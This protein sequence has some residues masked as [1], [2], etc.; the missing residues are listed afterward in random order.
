MVGGNYEFLPNFWWPDT[1]TNQY[2]GIIQPLHH[3]LMIYMK[4]NF[5]YKVKSLATV[6]YKIGSVLPF[7][8]LSAYLSV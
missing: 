7:V 5:I 2:N 1:H 3:S 4:V 8:H 6:S